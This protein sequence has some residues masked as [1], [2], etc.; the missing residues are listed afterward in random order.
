MRSA[1]VAG[2]REVRY[3]AAICVAPLRHH[4]MERKACI[5]TLHFATQP[6]H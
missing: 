6:S 3:P 2:N 5:E 4:V 1:G